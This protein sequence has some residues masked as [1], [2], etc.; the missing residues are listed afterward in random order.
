M[1]ELHESL[2]RA[3][4]KKMLKRGLTE[5]RSPI[6]TF[7]PDIFAQKTTVDGRVVE[8]VAVEAEIPATLF[9][10]HT[11]NQLIEMNHFIVLQRSKKIRAKGFLLIPKGTSPQLQANSLMDSLFPEGTRI[12]IV[13]L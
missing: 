10:E 12:R 5:A 2:I 13:Q 6:C 3:F 4:R 7:R 9:N 11:S 1:A 8:Q